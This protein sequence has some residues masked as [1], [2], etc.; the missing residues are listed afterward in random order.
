MT[1]R[2]QLS[3]YAKIRGVPDAFAPK[4]VDSL[5]TKLGLGKHA[6]KQCGSYSGGNK[7]KLSLA[8]ALVGDPSVLFLDEPSTGMVCLHEIPISK[9]NQEK[10]LV[11]SY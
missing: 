2:E 8:I 9:T 11:S 7:R 3:F 5:L 10:L 1:A 6:D 4:M